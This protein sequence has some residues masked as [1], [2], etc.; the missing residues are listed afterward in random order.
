MSDSESG[1]SFV[2]IVKDKRVQLGLAL[3]L[4]V[5][6]N[7]W[8][9]FCDGTLGMVVGVVVAIVS[10]FF[11]GIISVVL[12]VVVGI[13]SIV[14]IL[15]QYVHTVSLGIGVGFGL[16]IVKA[17]SKYLSTKKFE[18]YMNYAIPSFLIFMLF[19]LPI[20]DVYSE[21]ALWSGIFG[22]LVVGVLALT[23]LVLAIIK[24]MEEKGD[25]EGVV[26]SIFVVLGLSSC[27]VG[28]I[29]NSDIFFFMGC[30]FGGLALFLIVMD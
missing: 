4:L 11:F 22:Y 19:L 21:F 10:A 8:I 14:H 17:F 30:A 18:S 6:W 20:K 26:I 13:L 27:M 7:L 23:P 3:S 2:G 16:V 25:I 5:V 12:A 1:R 28:L 29:L 24:E 9:L 15:N